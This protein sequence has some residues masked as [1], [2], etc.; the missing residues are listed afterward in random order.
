MGSGNLVL[1]W[2]G[3]THALPADFGVRCDFKNAGRIVGKYSGPHG[4]VSTVLIYLDHSYGDRDEG[5]P[6]VYETLVFGGDNDG[7]MERY[8]SR[9]DAEAGHARMVAKISTQQ[10]EEE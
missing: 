10:G 1:V 2:D 4:D 3:T 6:L 8:T 7:D 9:A 5:P